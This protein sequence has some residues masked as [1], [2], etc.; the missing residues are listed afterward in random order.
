MMFD[1]I[2]QEIIKAS[3]EEILSV[4]ENSV[5]NFAK[6]LYS[7]AKTGGDAQETIDFI[8]K[9]IEAYSIYQDVSADSFLPEL[10][11]VKTR[12]KSFQRVLMDWVVALSTG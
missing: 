9:N 1:R 7:K 3:N 2:L 4:T 12:P 6:L 8:K 11:K 10:E 5:E